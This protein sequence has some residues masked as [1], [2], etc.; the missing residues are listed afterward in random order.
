MTVLLLSLEETIEG[1]SE[2]LTVL[3]EG[4]SKA[5]CK[6]WHSRSMRES[7][8]RAESAYL[9]LERG[10]TMTELEIRRARYITTEFKSLTIEEAL[11]SLKETAS[12]D[13]YS[14]DFLRKQVATL[15]EELLSL[16]KRQGIELAIGDYMDC[17]PAYWGS[18]DRCRY[19]V[20]AVRRQIAESETVGITELFESLKYPLLI[21][22]W[23]LAFT[24]ADTVTESG[25]YYT[26]NDHRRE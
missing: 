10:K 20:R 18:V 23:A 11:S 8:N 2:R 21:T 19:A 5:R 6:H 7:L 26:D 9:N 25:D 22:H 1:I 4:D 15:R 12:V 13:S 16:F 3:E 14:E 17:L 24:G